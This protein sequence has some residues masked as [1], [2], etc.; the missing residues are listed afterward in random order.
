MGFKHKLFVM[1]R[2]DL[3]PLI[4]RRNSKSSESQD[5]DSSSCTTRTVPGEDILK[6]LINSNEQLLKSVMDLREHQKKTDRELSAVRGELTNT[7]IFMHSL[8]SSLQNVLSSGLPQPNHYSP[9]SARSPS[10]SS[11]PPKRPQR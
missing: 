5:E 3:L 2:E 1:G 7:R 4:V 8:G 6:Q 11:T 9:S 10:Y